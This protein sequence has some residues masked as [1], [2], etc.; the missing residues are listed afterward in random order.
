[1]PKKN[2]S[3]SRTFQAL[4][5]AAFV[6]AVFSLPPVLAQGSS[7]PTID[8]INGEMVPET[9][10]I[11]ARALEAKGRYED[12]IKLLNICVR[13][14]PD[15]VALYFYRAKAYMKLKRF[16][17]AVLDCTAQIK[18]E[19]KIYQPYEMRAQCYLA[20]NERKKA[21]SDFMHV[22]EIAPGN[23]SAHKQLAKYYR[24]EGNL[25]NWKRELALAKN[26][27]SA[28]SASKAMLSPEVLSHHDH[29]VTELLSDATQALAR[30][31]P[32]LALEACKKALDLKERD[33][34][35]E[36]INKGE[37]YDLQAQAFQQMNLNDEAVV[38]FGQVLKFQPRNNRAY[39]LRAQSYFEIGKY[40][41]CIA[42]CDRS[43][44]GDKLLSNTV[45]ELR[46]SAV[47]RLKRR[48]ER[49]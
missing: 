12:M 26:S 21:Y 41:E 25:A 13:D 3:T 14:R 44:R 48:M 15:V 49:R 10:I 2:V 29:P 5:A 35:V 32:G 37:I 18:L 20:L 28:G 11:K 36:H 34:A 40:D 43:A 33:L 24:E 9:C 1:M 7:W 27:Q 4:F 45:A 22:V 16:R 17:E 38:A 47:G 30:K 31:K 23:S 19:K 8:K 46:A 39:Y 42:D 6:P